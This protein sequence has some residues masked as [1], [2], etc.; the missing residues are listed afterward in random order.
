[1]KKHIRLISL[2]LAAV[3]A[4]LSFTACGSSENESDDGSKI[5]MSYG[6]KTLSEKEFMY[7]ISLFKSQMVE[8]YQ[9]YF[10]QYGISYSESDILALPMS[11]DTTFE[12]YIKEISI[13]FSQQLLIYE[14][15]C[16]E[17]GISITDQEDIDMI[18]GN[19]EDMEIAF[20]GTDLFEINLAKAGITRAAIERYLRA[21]VLYELLYD[22]RYGDGGVAAIPAETINKQ[23]LENY[24]RYDGALYAYK[25]YDT[26]EAYTFEYSDED[27]LEY[28]NTD[29]VKVRHVLYLTVDSSNEKLS[30]DEVA[31]KK[32]K[33]EAA[34][35]SI[36]SGEKTM[37]DFSEENEDSGS[38][39]LFTYG[40]MV[41]A[42]ENAAFEM[43]VGEIRLV[44]TEYGFHI[45]EKLEK[46]S[47][48]LNGTTDEDGNVTG[49]CKDEVIEALTAKNIR[50]E[51]LELL[52]G[53]Q[54]GEITEYPEET[55]AKPYYLFMEAQLIDKSNTT[56][57]TFVE[58]V[59]NIE[60]GKFDEK[61]FE[62]DATYVI[63]RL[64]LTESDITADIYS[65]IEEDLAFTAFS[66][67]VQSFYDKVTVNNEILEN[68]D[69]VTIPNLDSDFYTFG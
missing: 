58:M 36:Q 57:A 6:N 8:Y 47:E 52:A 20:G 7:I 13:E 9:S 24:Y 3:M 37:E 15:I 34:F 45:V 67:Y 32:A 43:E 29:Y 5:V 2:L 68:F 31:A 39:Y 25:D 44:E 23:F 16:E 26:N 40:T 49:G 46:T 50:A 27:I 56:Y 28:F 60:I 69:V 11:E 14:A 22:Y 51:A 38:E 30:D 48:D 10:A 21:N 19:L 62:G 61:N 18:N 35:S 54:S 41:E 64:E 65:T 1:M 12:Q 33:A 4:L 55:D 63:R 59:S 66:E 42:F 17:A 53:L